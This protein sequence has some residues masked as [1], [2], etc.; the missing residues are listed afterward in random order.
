MSK[1]NRNDL[2]RKYEIIWSIRHSIRNDAFAIRALRDIPER[3]VRR[4]D[5]GGYIADESCLS[6]DGCCWVGGMAAVCQGSSVRDSALVT[7]GAIVTGESEITGNA[8]VSGKTKVAGSVVDGCAVVK[9]SAVVT[10]SGI[11][12]S[13]K[14]YDNATVSMSEVRG[15]SHVHGHSVLSSANVDAMADICGNAYVSRSFIYGNV[16]GSTRVIRSHVSS[17]S[18]VHGQATVTYAK[19]DD[20][21]VV[22]GNAKVGVPLFNDSDDDTYGTYVDGKAY[23][24]GRACVGKGRFG[25][26]TRMLVAGPVFIDDTGSPVYVTSIVDG[27]GGEHIFI[28]SG[29]GDDTGSGEIP[30]LGRG[31]EYIPL[32]DL[33]GRLLPPSVT[34]SDMYTEYMGP[35]QLQS[36]NSPAPRY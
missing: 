32:S 24:T 25:P 22:D 29:D 34:L 2:N 13:A 30:G 15:M 18:A 33:I 28:G 21:T 14:V 11:Y 5:Y 12:D 31:R 16:D 27:E 6:H 7:G 1:H 17:T 9:G 19:L 35:L 20:C 36:Q 26:S 4:G 3:N 23:I 8:L 10:K